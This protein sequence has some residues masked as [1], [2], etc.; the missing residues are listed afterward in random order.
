MIQGPYTSN[1]DKIPVVGSTGCFQHLVG[2]KAELIAA[3][4]SSKNETKYD[5]DLLW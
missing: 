4:G 5:L 3:Y 2:G 1:L